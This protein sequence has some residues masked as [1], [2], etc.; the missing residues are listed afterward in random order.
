MRSLGKISSGFLCLFKTK[1]VLTVCLPGPTE[2]RN[3]ATGLPEAPA[4][5]EGLLGEV[6]SMLLGPKELLQ[7]PGVSVERCLLSPGLP[8]A[9][10]I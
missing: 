2:A 7:I 5:V 4:A 1:N 3:R 10:L 9:G 8:R 6:P